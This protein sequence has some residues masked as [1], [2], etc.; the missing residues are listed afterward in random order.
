VA[1]NEDRYLVERCLSGVIF[2]VEY[3]KDQ[4]KT[5]T[6]CVIYQ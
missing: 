1:G 3:Q 4:S 6:V 5:C 2:S